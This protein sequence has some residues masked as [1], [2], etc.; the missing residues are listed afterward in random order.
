MTTNNDESTF[1]AVTKCHKSTRSH[2]PARVPTLAPP[3]LQPHSRA[4]T[5][6]TRTPPPT[7]APDRR[8]SQRHA[9]NGIHSN[10]QHNRCNGIDR[11]GPT[12]THTN[13]SHV[14]QVSLVKSVKSY[15]T[16]T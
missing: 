6:I 3:R 4:R 10:M 7:T 2:A 16:L 9:H 12:I 13:V 14:T 8:A 15:M 11:F 1:T 5:R